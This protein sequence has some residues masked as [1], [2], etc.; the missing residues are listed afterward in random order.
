MSQRRS[1]LVNYESQDFPMLT[2]FGNVAKYYRPPLTQKHLLNNKILH[3]YSNELPEFFRLNGM[4]KSDSVY[5]NPH[6]EDVKEIDRNQNNENMKSSIKYIKLLGKIKSNRSLSQNQNILERISSEEIIKKRK[7]LRDRYE[8]KS[9]NN[10]IMIP[11][12]TI[13]NL[14]NNNLNRIFKLYNKS[15]RIG[16]IRH[17]QID[18]NSLVYLDKNKNIKCSKLDIDKLKRLES[19]IDIPHSSYIANVNNYDIK[20]N[21]NENKRCV[22]EF[23][24][25]PIQ[26]YDPI[27]DEVKTYK[28]PNV[29]VNKWDKYNEAYSLMDDQLQC[30]GGLFSESFKKNR[31]NYK[32]MEIQKEKNLSMKKVSRNCK[33]NK[34]ILK[35]ASV[36]KLNYNKGKKVIFPRIKEILGYKAKD[37]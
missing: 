18:Q 1:P 29:K 2:K 9:A 4:Q 8:N 27:L 28:L 14:D 13:L 34:N 23:E 37:Y 11:K 7:I 25:I 15:M 10:V 22:F 33:S 36:D 6:L 20:E 19:V 3:Q 5:N 35:S 26:S 32:I 31:I 17:N 16:N 12:K 30:K 24:R 21:D